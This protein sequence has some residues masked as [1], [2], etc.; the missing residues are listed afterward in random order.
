MSECF[1]IELVAKVRMIALFWPGLAGRSAEEHDWLLLLVS[2]GAAGVL[3]SA[4][5]LA[6]DPYNIVG[7]RDRSPA[8]KSRIEEL[9]LKAGL[10]ATLE[11][12][13][14]KI[15]GLRKGGAASL[16]AEEADASLSAVGETGPLQDDDAPARSVQIA[17]PPPWDNILCLAGGFV[18]GLGSAS[19][20][21]D[22]AVTALAGACIMGLFFLFRK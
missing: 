22:A 5:S 13:R 9:L 2:R 21:C 3:A 11:A 8:L 6:A 20:W 10:G 15:G 14:I 18:L 12:T 4:A 1:V 19:S 17:R 7:L 16:S